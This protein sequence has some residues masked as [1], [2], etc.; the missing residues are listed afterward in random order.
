MKRYE[1]IIGLLICLGLTFVF[2]SCEK[3]EEKSS[4]KIG[5]TTEIEV[6]ETAINSKYG[7]SLRVENVDDSRCPKEVVC[8]W[9]GEAS[10]QLQLTTREGEYNF[11]LKKEGLDGPSCE[12][13]VIEGLKYE[14]IDVLP[15]PGS[16]T[17][18]VEKTVKL[19]VTEIIKGTF[20]GTFSVMYSDHVVKGTMT[21]ELKNGKF[22]VLGFLHDQ[23]EFSGNYSMSNN[24]ITF[25]IKVWKTDYIDEDGN[26]IAYDFDT[27]IVP[28]GEYIYT[29][30]GNKLKFS[31]TYDDL[32]RN[33]EWEFTKK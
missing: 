21:L 7:L 9:A 24:K 17:E 12:G 18:R 31:R 15:Y 13:I 16:E 10:V 30:G 14:L 5:K 11:T 8:I 29:F 2:S 6:G 22:S 32:N 33:Y 23:A 25:D 27:F 28:Q 19:L 20:P 3:E 1:F 4:L 26:G